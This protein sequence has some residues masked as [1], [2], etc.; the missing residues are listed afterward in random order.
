MLADTKSALALTDPAGPM[1]SYSQILKRQSEISLD[2]NGLGLGFP[3]SQQGFTKT[4]WSGVRSSTEASMTVGEL[5]DGLERNFVVRNL[6]S[7]S[8]LRHRRKHIEAIFG[9]RT[10]HREL[11]WAKGEAYIVKRRGEGASS[12][13]IRSEVHYLERALKLAVRAGLI[14]SA[15][16]LPHIALDPS[17]V[18]RGFL[19]EVDLRAVC[20]HLDAD[21][22]DLVWFLFA[23][24]WRVSEATGL[25]WADVDKDAIR[26]RD[27]KTRQPRVVPISGEIHQIILRREMLARG[28]CAFVFHR[29]GRQIKGFRKRWMSACEAGGVGHRLVHDLRRSGIR[30]MI[31][32]GVDRNTAMAF[33]G[34][35]TE[36]T[37]RRYQIVDLPRMRWATEQVERVS[38]LMPPWRAERRE[39]DDGRTASQFRAP[40][41]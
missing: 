23:T 36:A 19:D 5:M 9:A 10:Q 39:G 30:R 41:R 29:H 12:S 37:F 18:R 38:G 4:A 15:P 14:R 35:R 24:A 7:L 1:G 25:V 33:S 8:T 6:R 27:S 40:W 22:A 20:R 3:L 21:T 26:L 32:S 16:A 31:Q 34:H 17:R 28:N 11:T 13:S 2:L